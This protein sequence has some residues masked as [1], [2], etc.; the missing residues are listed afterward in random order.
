MVVCEQGAC[1]WVFVDAF[2]C[3]VVVEGNFDEMEDDRDGNGMAWCA[4]TWG[5]GIL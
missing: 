3:W 1:V 5:M 4:V 2:A